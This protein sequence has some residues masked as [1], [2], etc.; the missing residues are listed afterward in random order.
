MPIQITRNHFD[1]LWLH[2]S[3]QC[4]LACT[5]CLFSCSAYSVGP[6]D[7]SLRE[8]QDYVAAALEQGVKAI[9][10][11]GGEP[12][13]WPGLLQ[14]LT[15]YYARE[16]DVPLTILTNGTL[17]TE[18]LA[19]KLERYA[20]QGLS[21]RISLECYTPLTHEKFRGPGSFERAVQGIRSLNAEGIRPWIG[22]VSKSGGGLTKE[23]AQALEFDF[24]QHLKADFDVEI[25]GL[26]IISA[27]SKGRFKGQ[28]D[29]EACASQIE[30]RLT[31][32]QCAYGVAVSK[33][34]VFPCPILVDE[35]DAVMPKTLQGLSG[36]K[37]ELDYDY[38]A[39]CFA[40]GTSC[41]Q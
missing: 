27:Y 6:G 4:N 38:C 1:E 36:Q 12:M 30:Q 14:F 31:T 17:I 20:R 40:T 15:W 34:G 16:T 19:Q 23:E 10:I 13:Q 9:Y 8:G 28:A 25:N 5:H 24:R 11:T 41:G 33:A 26:K 22:F 37:V 32:V 7:L 3:Y 35:P 2:V 21:L 39:S 18:E 29:V